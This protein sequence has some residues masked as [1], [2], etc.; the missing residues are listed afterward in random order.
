MQPEVLRVAAGARRARS[1]ELG[2]WGRSHDLEAVGHMT[3]ASPSH[4][5]LL[6]ST[7]APPW[8]QE[9]PGAAA[10]TGTGL[11]D[12]GGY[13]RLP[14]P[15]CRYLHCP[16]QPHHCLSSHTQLLVFLG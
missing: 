2:D 4:Q 16:S 7:Q 13:H 9:L 12:L 1:P 14:R 5:P 10:G 11:Q 6:P 15:F 3:M 8:A